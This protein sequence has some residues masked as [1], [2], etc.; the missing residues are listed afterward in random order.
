[1]PAFFILVILGAMLLWLCCS[2]IFA[3]LGRFV[4]KLLTDAKDAMNKEDP[5]E[6]SNEEKEST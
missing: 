1:M 5:I 3:P 6:D 2:F 4:S